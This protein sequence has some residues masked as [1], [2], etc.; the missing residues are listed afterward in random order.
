MGYSPP[1]FEAVQTLPHKGNRLS[2]EQPDALRIATLE[3]VPPPRLNV[4]SK[5]KYKDVDLATGEESVVTVSK[6]G[7]NSKRRQDFRH[8][9]CL[10]MAELKHT[11]EDAFCELDWP[12]TADHISADRSVLTR[13]ELTAFLL[14]DAVETAG[15]KELD[16]LANQQLWNL[17][18]LF[19][20]IG[21]AF[22]SIH[23][24]HAIDAAL[25]AHPL[26]PEFEPIRRVSRNLKSPIR[27]L[28]EI[29]RIPN[30]EEDDL[31]GLN[32]CGGPFAIGNRVQQLAPIEDLNVVT[33]IAWMVSV[34][35][36]GRTNESRLGLWL[37]DP[38]GERRS[39]IFAITLAPTRDGIS[40]D[41]PLT[42]DIGT[43]EL[44]QLDKA[45]NYL[46]EYWG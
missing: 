24:P 38:N 19:S 17:P 7:L 15:V 10:A 25:L 46:V 29:L 3:F 11:T 9:T 39:D 16:I 44:R 37:A 23:D 5:I 36:S 18:Q 34:L 4:A 30:I 6:S 42:M 8:L 40:F 43:M 27:R 26:A 41:L 45:Q 35:T 22:E 2:N 12:N 20:A 1:W 14:D 13:Q 21:I 32:L 31:L 28:A 33:A